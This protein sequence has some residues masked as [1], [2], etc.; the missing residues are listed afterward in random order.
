[1]EKII[2]V[3]PFIEK[4]IL[5]SE[6]K[7]RIPIVK[8]DSKGNIVN[9]HQEFWTKLGTYSFIGKHFDAL[10]EESKQLKDKLHR[11]NAQIK[12]LKKKVAFAIQ[13]LKEFGSVEAV[14]ELIG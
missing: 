1:M 2:K 12:E 6:G 8:Q 7:W 13:E 5:A 3:F 4:G 14:Q 10:E 11:R 9:S